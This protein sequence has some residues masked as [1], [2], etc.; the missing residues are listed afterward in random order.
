MRL[1]QQTLNPTKLLE[2]VYELFASSED[3]GMLSLGRVG[4][5]QGCNW[6]I[7]PGSPSCIHAKST[8]GLGCQGEGADTAW[9]KDML[10]Q[11]EL[12]VGVSG[13]RQC[14]L[15]GCHFSV[16]CWQAP[17]VLMVARGQGALC[18][19]IPQPVP[20]QTVP[21]APCLSSTASLWRRAIS[22]RGTDVAF[23]HREKR[24]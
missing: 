1:R 2:V 6:R 16:L 19:P 15:L 9:L 8:G 18:S 12:Q 21:G 4:R 14:Q 24:Q 17:V 11:Q 22:P 3:A 7:L 23:T 13:H 10:S 5:E 20:G